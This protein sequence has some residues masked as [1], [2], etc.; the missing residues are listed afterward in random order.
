MAETLQPLWI[1]PPT[2]ADRPPPADREAWVSRG[3]DT[4]AAVTSSEPADDERAAP[5]FR[6]GRAAALEALG[7]IDPPGYARS[8]NFLSGR[9]TRL[10]PWLR[11]GVLSTAEVR[12]LA[13][14]RAGAEA[15]KLVSELGWRDYWRRV[16]A[17]LGERIDRDIE[18]PAAIHRRKAAVEMPSDVIEATT[19]MACIDHFVRELHSTGYLHNHARMW[20]AAWLVHARGVRWQAGAAWFLRHL[21]DGDPASNTLS[22]QWVAGSFSAK[23]YIFN[24]DN[25]DR[26]SEGRLCGACPLAGHCDL[27][28]DYETLEARWFSGFPSRDRLRIAPAEPWR[29]AELDTKAAA[30]VWL[31][32]DSLGTTS[33]A[34]VARP[35]AMRV[36]VFDPAWLSRVRPTRKRLRFV[37][38]CLA[39]VPRLALGVGPPA[40]L[41]AEAAAVEQARGIAV[42]ETPCPGVRAEADRLAATLPVEVVDWPPLVPEGRITDLGRF[43]RYWS[44]VKQAAMLPTPGRRD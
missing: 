19:G 10:S 16:H 41:V 36:F 24:R 40:E 22:W 21:V 1:E 15:E 11:H 37:L 28:G 25:L 31:T 2:T 4:L 14:A 38:E 27:E 12:D 26:F 33:P 32:L 18:T 7:E 8:R 3:L 29:L 20:T 23:P 5:L 44:R 13:L 42:A 17:S 34:A 43:S 9:V 39:D 30:V 35:E 6:G